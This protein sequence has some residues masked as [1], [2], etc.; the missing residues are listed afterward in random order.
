MCGCVGVKGCVGI[1]MWSALVWRCVCGRGCVAT[2]V[3]VA[4][5]C[6]YLD[7]GGELAG[8]CEDEHDRAVTGFEWP[9]RLDV[10][11]TWQQEG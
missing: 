9:L 1:R 2:W 8:R 7:L 5:M 3:W 6:G 11:D 4:W 10:L